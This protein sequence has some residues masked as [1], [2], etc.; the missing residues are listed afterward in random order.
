M[1][2]NVIRIQFGNAMRS[3]FYE[4]DVNEIQEIYRAMKLFTDYCYLPE[5]ILKIQMENGE[6]LFFLLHC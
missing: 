2:G 6:F 3:W 5:N 1:D 4:C